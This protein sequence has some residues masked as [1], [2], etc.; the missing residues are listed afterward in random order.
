MGIMNVIILYDHDH[1]DPRQ[2]LTNN[3]DPFWTYTP[4]VIG[5]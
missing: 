4:T 2:T 1:H 5:E 3:D